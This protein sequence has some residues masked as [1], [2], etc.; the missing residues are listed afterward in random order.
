[1]E[2]TQTVR[3]TRKSFSERRIYY[4]RDHAAMRRR[5]LLLKRTVTV[6][7]PRIKCT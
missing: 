4:Y 3:T 2:G 1:M 6:Q 5:N 7:S